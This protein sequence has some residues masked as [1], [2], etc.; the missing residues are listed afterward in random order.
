MVLVRMIYASTIA[1]DLEKEAINKIMTCSKSENKKQNITGLL[2]FNRRYFLQ[3]LEGERETV[4]KLFMK[5]ARDERHKNV[6]ISE[7]V[8][9]HQ[10]EFE[11]WKMGYVP[12][13]KITTP[14][15]LKYSAD[16]KFNPYAMSSQ[17]QLAMMLELRDHVSVENVE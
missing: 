10:R 14:I 11:S 16:T 5:I 15:I 13:S 8:E 4:N 2:Y 1:S 12:E 3:V 17:S 7:L 6:V 9:V